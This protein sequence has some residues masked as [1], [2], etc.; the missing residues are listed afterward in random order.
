MNTTTRRG[1][2]RGVAGF[3]LALPWLESVQLPAA[4][5]GSAGKPAPVRYMN[6]FFATGWSQGGKGWMASGSGADFTLGPWLKPLEPFQDRLIQFRNVM[7]KPGIHAYLR[8]YLSG[9]LEGIERAKFKPPAGAPHTVDQVLADAWAEHTE[10]PCFVLG[11]DNPVSAIPN[12]DAISWR[13][14]AAVPRLVNPAEAFDA[15]FSGP[16]QRAK[17]RSVLDLVRDQARALE[18]SSSAADRQRLEQYQTAIR[19]IERRI[20]QAERPRPADAWQPSLREPDMERPAG[21]PAELPRY[22]RLMLD[23]A[24]LALRMDK[25]RVVTLML[26]NES[27]HRTYD[28]LPGV[29]GGLHDISH[30]AGGPEAHA[31]IVQYNVGLCAEFLKKC[32]SVDEGDGTLFDHLLLHF[33]SDMS[34]GGGHSGSDIPFLLLGGACGR[35]K[36][37]RIID[38]KGAFLGQANLSILRMLGVKADRFGDVVEELAV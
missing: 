36:G 25:T 16:V 6:L 4:E 22:Q 17:R 23:I 9:Y 38:G 7:N 13:V 3:T 24:L 10:L 26:N 18:A 15:L 21:E 20:E 33:G 35:L 34:D 8:N 37:R 28:F 5:K 32:Q 14:G 30:G 11:S 27:S 12:Q 2:L 19:D 31:R 1:F 29:K